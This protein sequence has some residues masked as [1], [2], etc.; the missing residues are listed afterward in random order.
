MSRFSLRTRLTVL[1]GLAAALTLAGLTVGFNLLLRSNLNGDA[2]RVLDARASA[3]LDGVSQQ[4]GILKVTESPDSTAPETPVWVYDSAGNAIDRPVAP[5]SAQR[6]ADSLAGGPRT[7]AQDPRADL[8]L[9]GVPVV[10]GGRRAG[11]IVTAVSLDP[12]ERSA[13]RALTESLIYAG[14]AFLLVLLATRLIVNRALRPVAEMTEE[15]ADWSEHDL[16]HRFNVG[17]PYDELTNLAATFDNMLARLA[18]ALRHEQLL[19]AELSHE[20]RTP[21]AAIVTEAELALR[22]KRGDAEYRE[23]LEEIAERASQMHETLETLM[24]AARAESMGDRG[25]ASAAEVVERT[26]AACEPLADK[27]GVRLSSEVSDARIKV[28]VDSATAE[29]IIGPLLENACRYGGGQVAVRVNRDNGAAEFIVSDDGPGLAPDEKERIFEPG[30]RGEAGDGK[31]GGAGLGLALSR[32][33]ARAVGGDVEAIANGS[34][35]SFRARIP[36][37]AG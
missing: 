27:T 15:A 4:G 3:E 19:S 30:Y 22:H 16:E 36:L 33:L 12:Y 31:D 7:L 18:S 5:A 10:K 20:L 11:T 35:A 9:L 17:E 32:R 6:L 1:V 13:S 26:L 24:A 34:G 28:D 23:A 25:T 2:N 14:A 21:L 37:S 8:H 29:R